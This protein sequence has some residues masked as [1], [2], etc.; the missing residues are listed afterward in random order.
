MGRA[1]GEIKK[2]SDF[3]VKNPKSVHNTGKYMLVLAGKRV[4]QAQLFTKK[5]A[6]CRFDRATDLPT[7]RGGLSVGQHSGKTARRKQSGAA[8]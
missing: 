6:T 3:H 1:E 8:G 5:F 2:I 4:K 7:V